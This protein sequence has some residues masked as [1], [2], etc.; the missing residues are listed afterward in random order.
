VCSGQREKADARSAAT[1]RLRVEEVEVLS[2]V[3]S[4]DDSHEPVPSA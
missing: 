2:G 3:V 1:G 4:R